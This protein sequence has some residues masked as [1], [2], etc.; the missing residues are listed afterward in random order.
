MAHLHSIYDSDTHFIID[1]I[2]RGITSES[3]KVT[4]MQNDHLSER[5]TFELP[6]YIEGHDMSLTD[7]VE[8]HY[9]NIDGGNKRSY[10]A[11]VYESNDL[12]ISPD[13]NDVVIC[14]WLIS[15]NA[16]THA[17][18]LSFNLRFVC[19]DGESIDYQWFTDTFTGIK[20]KAAI[21]NSDV[22][23][24]NYDMDIIEGWKRD[25][26]ASFYESEA[27][28]EAERFVTETAV[29]AGNAAQSAAA[30]KASE[31]NSKSL[32][33]E[34]KKNISEGVYNGVDGIQ[35]PQGEKGEKGDPGAVGPMGPKGATGATGA[36]GQ[37]GATGATGPR[38]AEG[39]KG[40]TGARGPVGP[41]GPAGSA[42]PQG[43][44]GVQGEKG[45]PGDSGVTAPLSGFFTL[46]VDPDGSLY[47]L[48]NDED[49]GNSFEL[50][51]E[52]NLYLVQE[53]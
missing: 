27:Y 6:R 34:V 17:G 5:F 12:Q 25:V 26:I 29:Y 7:K 31:D 3:G 19:Y 37:R 9:I 43:P 35:G 13:S 4:L 15:K 32:L 30:A 16:T 40:D 1:P 23:D 46:G 38:G 50:D 11:D 10:N 28:A 42:G 36:T 52:G 47:A 51:E 49:A 41:A 45:D 44:Q 24:P 48:V 22:L 2:N 8:V 21:Y 18:S 14:S 53:V 39:P 20:V 33:D